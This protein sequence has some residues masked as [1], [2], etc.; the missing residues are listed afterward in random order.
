M[1][2]PNHRCALMDALSV[3]FLKKEAVGFG[4]RADI[5]RKPRIAAIL[6][7]LRILP[8]S[9]ER[10]GLHEVAH[11]LEIF[12]EIVE[13]LDRDMPFCLF[14]EGTHRPQKGL[15]PIKKGIFRVSRMAHEKLGKPVYIVPVGLD[16][17]DFRHEMGKMV[18]RVGEAF[19]LGQ[20]EAEHSELGEAELYQSLRKELQ[21]RL[22]AL[23]DQYPERDHGHLFLRT[24]ASIL[25]LPL[26]II[27]AAGS[28]PIWLSSELILGSM[29][30]KA[31]A[32]TVVI[33]CRIIFPVLWPFWW[34]YAFLLRFYIK[35]IEDFRK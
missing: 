3:L 4:A 21:T 33:V 17:E 16:Y 18:I 22:L 31:W 11:N 2:A 32:H 15:L 25:S 8:I 30:D 19:E 29:Q 5:F 7:W 34:L 12:D 27:G 10:D 20:F 35:L 6:N 24:L 23:I 26:F 1:L 28:F 9:R 13:C 14:S